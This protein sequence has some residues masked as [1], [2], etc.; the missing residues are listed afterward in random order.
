MITHRYPPTGEI[1]VTAK[2]FTVRVTEE[3]VRILIEDAVVHE[4]SP[5]PKHDDNTPSPRERKTT[6]GSR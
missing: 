6:R 1:T 4:W 2:D 5:K 3:G